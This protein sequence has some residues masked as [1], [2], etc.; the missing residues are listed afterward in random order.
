MVNGT[1]LTPRSTAGLGASGEGRIMGVENAAN[2]E[3]AKV[4]EVF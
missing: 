1:G 3:L 4:E 2:N